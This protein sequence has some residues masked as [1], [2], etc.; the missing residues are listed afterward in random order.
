MARRS[1][2]P[3]KDTPLTQSNTQQ[4]DFQLVSK[5]IGLFQLRHPHL[6]FCWASADS[7]K[8]IQNVLRSLRQGLQHEGFARS[9]VVCGVTAVRPTVISHSD[10]EHL[11][12]YSECL[13]V[14]SKS[15]GS[16]IAGLTSLHFCE[17]VMELSSSHDGHY[18]THL[19]NRIC[20]Q[21]HALSGMGFL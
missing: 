1:K 2:L 18:M 4:V 9:H 8:M 12:G 20:I 17:P 11:L 21:T 14:R 7:L 15:S 19:C 10:D 6:C 3:C 5:P 13:Q 16:C